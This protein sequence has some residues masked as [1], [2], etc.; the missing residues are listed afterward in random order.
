[1]TD[2]NT[3]QTT[4]T[5]TVVYTGPCRIQQQVAQGSAAAPQTPGQDYQMLVGLE[6]Q[7]PVVGSEGLAVSDVAT[8]TSAAHDEEMVGLV[9]IVRELA[10]KT[11]A[12]TRRVGVT[13]RTS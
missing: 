8:I 13:R 9:L 7:L 2:G 6:L 4:Y 5:E 1:V 10:A 11:D 3:G 12:S